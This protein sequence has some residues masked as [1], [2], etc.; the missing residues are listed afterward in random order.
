MKCWIPGCEGE[1]VQFLIRYE[2]LDEEVP[3]LARSECRCAE[4]RHSGRVKNWREVT[5]QE[6]QQFE[7][8]RQVHRS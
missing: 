1:P 8:L 6:P 2:F 7:L 5:L 4:H 3:G